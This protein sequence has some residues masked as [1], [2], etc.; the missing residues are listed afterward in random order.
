MLFRY[1]LGA[2]ETNILVAGVLNNTVNCLAPLQQKGGFKQERQR[3]AE[4]MGRRATCRIRRVLVDTDIT[5]QGPFNAVF[6]LT[7]TLVPEPRP[8]R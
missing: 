5:G 3:S 6:S 8:G 1:F 4:L 7:G 2:I